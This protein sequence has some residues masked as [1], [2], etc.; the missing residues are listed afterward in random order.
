MI[1]AK[2]L[3]KMY[4]N[5][6]AAKN[7]NFSVKPG[8][9]FGLLGPNGAGESTIFRMMCGLLRPTSGQAVVTGL[10]LETASGKARANIGY[11]AQKFSLY[12]D[13]SVMQNL[14]FFSG[15]Y[16]LRGRKQKQRID[17]IVDIFDF[18]KYLDMNAGGLPFRQ[19]TNKDWR[20]PA[21]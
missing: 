12:R 8:E 3:T 21:Q 19:V 2:N 15:A 13:L 4:G 5:F 10:N 16:G 1:E 9:I 7:V 6:A 18:K 14:K 20:S 17:T 11:M